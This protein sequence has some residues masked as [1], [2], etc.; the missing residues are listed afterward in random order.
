MELINP[1]NLTPCQQEAFDSLDLDRFK[2]YLEQI[3][4]QR[5]ESPNKNFD[6]FVKPPKHKDGEPVEVP[7]IKH[8]GFADQHRRLAE[9]FNT[10]G[11]IVAVEK[12]LDGLTQFCKD[13]MACTK[14]AHRPRS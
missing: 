6:L 8:M 12:G 9:A 14:P 10:V 1:F 11:M 2:A 4:W 13:F 3:G 5:M 7:I